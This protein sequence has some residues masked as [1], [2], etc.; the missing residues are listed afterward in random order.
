MTRFKDFASLLLASSAVAA[1]SISA[2]SAISCYDNSNCPADY[3]VCTNA[4]LNKKGLCSKSGAGVT[5]AVRIAGVEGYAKGS[6]VRGLVHVTVI[7]QS[8]TGVQDV[9]LTVS[10]ATPT[11]TRNATMSNPPAYVFDVDTGNVDG[12]ATLTA[13]LTPGAG[14]AVASATWDLVFDNTP[15]TLTI[16]APS[17]L[18]V[19]DGML[20]TFDVTSSE[21][22]SSI[23][24]NISGATTALAQI[25]P[26]TGLVYHFGYAVTAGDAAGPHGISVSGADLLG[27]SNGASKGAAFSVRHPFAFGP[28]T[29][30]TGHTV[31]EVS[32]ALPA[33]TA[34]T[35]VSVS[36]SLPASASLG[37]AKPVFQLTSA[38][39]PVRM[40]AAPTLTTGATVNTW[41]TTYPVVVA[42][43]DGVASVAV[44]VT[45]LAG[46]TPAP[47]VANLSIDKSP[48]L[49]TGAAAS[50]TYFDTTVPHN[51]V[52]ITT[53]ASKRLQ[54]ATIAVSN[55]DLGTCTC[56]GGAC[57]ASTSLT[58]LVRCS[59]VVS[60]SPA[61]PVATLTLR[62]TLGNSSSGSLA[63]ASYQASYTVV[64][65][66]VNGGLSGAA[67]IGQGTS[68]LLT[69]TFTNGVGTITGDDG[70][71]YVLANPTPISVSPVTT[72]IYSLVV[73]NAAGTPSGSSLATVMVV[74]AA[75]IG[76]FTGPQY[77][78]LGTAKTTNPVSLVVTFPSGTASVVATS[79][80]TGLVCASG[81]PTVSPATFNCLEATNGFNATTVFTATV[82]GATSATATTTV[83]AA[84]DPADASTN[85]LSP[86]SAV[87]P[88]STASLSAKACSGCTAVVNPGNISATADGTAHAVTT[89]TLQEDTSFTLTI[90]NLAGKTVN[91]TATQLVNRP[92]IGSFTGPQYATLGTAKTTNPVSLVVTFP[93]GGTA[94]VVATSGATGLVCASGAATVSPATFNCLDPTNGFNATTLFTAKVTLGSGMTTATATVTGATDPA[95]TS[96]TLTTA[97]NPLTRDQLVNP[98]TLNYTYCAGCTATLTNGNTG[99]AVS[100]PG[101]S[102]NVTLIRTTTYTLTATNLAG[103]SASATPLTVTVLPGLFAATANA[104]GA[105]RFGAVTVLLPNGTILIAGGRTDPT[106]ASTAVSSAQIYDPGNASTPF[107]VL[108]ANPS[109]AVSTMQNTRYRAAGVL[110]PDGRVYISGGINTVPS[111]VATADIF[112]PAADGFLKSGQGQPANLGTGRWGHT[113]TVLPSG[114]VVLAGG[115]SDLAGAT[116]ISNLDLFNPAAFG[117]TPAAS[118]AT[119]TYARG[120]HTATAGADGRVLVF[121]GVISGSIAQQTSA[122]F[123]SETTDLNTDSVMQVQRAYHTATALADGRILLVGGTTAASSF[124][125]LI[126]YTPSTNSITSVAGPVS[127]VTNG[128]RFAHTATPLPFGKVLIAGGY[129]DSTLATP[130]STAE[131]YTPAT[132]PGVGT[133]TK[134]SGMGSIATPINRAQHGSAFVFS[135]KAVLIG[136]DTVS[137]TAETFDPN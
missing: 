4:S 39:G 23:T 88:G 68:T 94:S 45:D 109:I 32:S 1:C 17:A 129:T 40:L 101:T 108:S 79:G 85:S 34:G 95:A 29:I 84:N 120:N 107:R 113:A 12:T 16:G 41:A 86:G 70:S 26:P 30:S 46:N 2:D 59:V 61:T 99:V 96:P 90:T 91:Y 37:S 119:L 50:G 135:G 55:L 137:A 27:N 133:M 97:T 76:S 82:T 21:P 128:A 35:L 7:A 47:A 110:L 98:V 19:A 111:V 42:D 112:D 71:S 105:N 136:G 69:P 132:S 10:G 124:S 122:E 28:L 13:H 65:A 118:G 33:A 89:G 106:N 57:N 11:I 63:I 125:E 115:F 14:D 54:S 117:T 102:L 43:N 24:G 5:A 116:R 87:N 121:G 53:I 83:T 130:Q 104:P 49:S 51:T 52:V 78:T 75:N 131:L 67:T 80:A 92:I 60:H 64:P 3:P 48:P 56:D 72:T 77:A 66:P 114:K 73:K 22:L 9:S 74:P 20:V 38:G 15:P 134:T 44:A 36:V 6:P 100:A 93:S 127:A 103:A 81:A 126:T 25:A 8:S 62:D 123:V 58:P 18:E 31:N